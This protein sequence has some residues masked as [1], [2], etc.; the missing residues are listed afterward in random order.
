MLPLD[1]W[2]SDSRD[3]ICSFV[4]GRSPVVRGAAW[5]AWLAWL[6]QVAPCLVVL[7]PTSQ[8]TESQEL[9]RE[10][11]RSTCSLR[12]PGSQ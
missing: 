2:L 11:S 8:S 10:R 4:K 1:D 6:A 9:R 3:P 12:R 5:L 7:V